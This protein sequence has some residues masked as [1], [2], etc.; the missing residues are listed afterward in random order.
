MDD[1][2]AA[3]IAL[4]ACSS[5]GHFI[6]GTRIYADTSFMLFVVLSLGLLFRG[7]R[8]EHPARLLFVS[9][10]VA[11]LALS[12]RHSG[13]ALLIAVPS[14]F[15]AA[16]LLRDQT[17]RIAA[18]RAAYWIAGALPIYL[19]LMLLAPEK[20]YRFVHQG[21]DALT[22][23]RSYLW[24]LIIDLTGLESAAI[25]AWDY[26]I[27]LFVVLPLG[28]IIALG[29]VLAWL[30]QLDSAQRFAVLVLL[31]YLTIGAAMVTLAIYLWDA[32]GKLRYV[33]KQSWI[34]MALTVV[35][36]GALFQRS[37]TQR[38]FLSAAGVL[39]L[40][41]L[42]LGRIQYVANANDD[43]DRFVRKHLASDQELIATVKSLPT[44]AFVV[45]TLGSFLT[46]E[47]ER[48]VR[49]LRRENID[50]IYDQLTEAASAVPSHRQLFAV[51]LPIS[52][53]WVESRQTW[54]T[55]FLA[56]LESPYVIRGRTPNMILL[57]R[58]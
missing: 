43:A 38:Q 6:S 22:A 4:L 7:M 2:P 26:R 46:Y 34:L 24:N 52:D 25:A 39:I 12:M 44:N 41:I 40:G 47:A 11:S 21:Q 36:T 1:L 50:T 57:E 16:A 31:A 28:L 51:I 30:H 54:Q 29:I 56:E 53:W 5:P 37:N 27:L 14:G 18:S 58:E 32:I 3:A 20:Q 49:N 19:A 13:I 15:L 23:V 33:T 17:I 48:P 42:I 10:A 35:A 45:S 9:G 55:E 8:S